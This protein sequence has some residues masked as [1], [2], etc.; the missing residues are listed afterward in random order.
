M[1]LHHL[2]CAAALAALSACGRPPQPVLG[3]HCNLVGTSELNSHGS[4]GTITKIA[5]DW[6]VLAHPNGTEP[7]FN[8]EHIITIHYS[9]WQPNKPMQ[10]DR[11]TVRRTDPA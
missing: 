3:E 7:W 5:D 2:M 8:L 4:S 11:P 9:G 10:T 6:I 1:K